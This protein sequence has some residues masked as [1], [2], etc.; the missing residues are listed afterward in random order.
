MSRI[1]DDA[2]QDDTG[3]P[4]SAY[5]AVARTMTRGAALYFSRP[6]RLFRPS[7]V[8]GWQSLRGLAA[9][10]GTS[11]SPTFVTQLIR[12]HGLLVIP[13]HFVPP[14]LVNAALG[15]VLWAT[16]AESSALLSSSGAL[17]T[18]PIVLAAISGAAAGGAQ[19]IVAAPAENVRLAIE[20]GNSTGGWSHAWK[21][22]FR[23]VAPIRPDAKENLREIRRVRSWM[24]EVRDMAGRGWNG[25]GWTLAKDVC[26][27]AVFFSIFEVTRRVASELKIMS[28]GLLQP[29]KIS[30]GRPNAVQ[31]NLPRVVHGVSLVVGGVTAGLAYEVVCRPWDAARRLAYLDHVQ[32]TTAHQPRRYLISLLVHKARD[33]GIGSFFRA[34]GSGSGQ[35]QTTTPSSWGQQRLLGLARTLARVGPWGV[36]FLVWEAFGPGIS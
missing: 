30:E 18:H 29:F 34:P 12:S 3:K 33:D 1:A 20:G 9:S 19:A 21:E 32:S 13:K 22:V 28:L 25:W 4:N 27:F 5:A 17:G 7:K 14:L 10:N 24:A 15:T 2:A 8:S 11:L 16:Y 35:P 36:G 23:G 6:V 31:R 26:G